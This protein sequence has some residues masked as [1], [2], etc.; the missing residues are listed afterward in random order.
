L[1]ANSS[2]LL[3]VDDDAGHRNML[4]RRLVHRGYSVEVAES[5]AAAVEKIEAAQY[6]LVLL[7]QMMPGTSGIDLLR[8]LRATRSQTELPVI[9]LTAADQSQFAVDALANGA[10]DY[11]TKPVDLPVVAARI[12][13]QLL[14]C[15]I[16]REGKRVDRLTGLGNRTLL[17]EKLTD[18]IAK[19]HD[20]GEP[21]VMAVVLLDL[22]GFKGVNDGFGH[23]VGDQL[24][25][26]VGA[27]LKGKMEADGHPDTVARVG[28]D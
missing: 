20:S 19:Q 1:P 17:I 3:V 9:M 28:G 14:R 8:L 15:R 26:E 23:S 22:D 12:Q 10:N 21:G 2:K 25:I 18:S 24:L 27:R 5:G 13:T 6:D 11:V 16:D 4:S 7:D